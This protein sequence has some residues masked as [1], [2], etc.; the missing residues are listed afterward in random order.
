MSPLSQGK[1]DIE[2]VIV[3]SET[4]MNYDGFERLTLSGRR[5]AIQPAGLD[6]VV[7]S[8]NDNQ[9]TLVSR[10]QLFFAKCQ[11]KSNRLE[12]SLTRPKFAET[13]VINARDQRDTSDTVEREVVQV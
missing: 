1:W 8:I 3:N 2:S 10:G 13:I 5:I 12:L 11:Q 7:D 6:F 9:L 4:I